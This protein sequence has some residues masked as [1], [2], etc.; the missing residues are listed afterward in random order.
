M[1]LE[2]VRA[3]SLASARWSDCLLC[4]EQSLPLLSCNPYLC[5][6]Q[7]AFLYDY[8]DSLTETLA[9]LTAHSD[10]L[11]RVRRL[12]HRVYASFIDVGRFAKYQ[13]AFFIDDPPAIKRFIRLMDQVAHKNSDKAV[14]P[15]A[16]HRRCSRPALRAPEA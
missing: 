6:L 8:L 16:A 9:N 5:I 10:E 3:Q 7:P 2:V 11:Q 14:R 13:P 12:L 15:T 1:N 4:L